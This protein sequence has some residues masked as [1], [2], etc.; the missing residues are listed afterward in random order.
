VIR[1]HASQRLTLKKFS[2]IATAPT[3]DEQQIP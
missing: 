1:S 3:K 2:R